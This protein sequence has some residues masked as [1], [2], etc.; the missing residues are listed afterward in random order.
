MRYAPTILRYHE[1]MQTRL[2]P[3]SRPNCTLR[4]TAMQMFKNLLY[5]TQNRHANV[6]S[7]FVHGAKPSCKRSITDC[8]L[9]KTSMQMFHA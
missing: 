1:M 2:E 8:S 6:Q 3:T 5:T 9:C 4:K 7:P